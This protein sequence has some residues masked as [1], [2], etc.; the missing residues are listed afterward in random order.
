MEKKVVR[1]ELGEEKGGRIVRRDGDRE[2]C[3]D[4]CV[5]TQTTCRGLCVWA[6]QKKGLDSLCFKNISF[7]SFRGGMESTSKGSEEEEKKKKRETKPRWWPWGQLGKQCGVLWDQASVA[8]RQG[9]DGS[10][11]PCPFGGEG[12]DVHGER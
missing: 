8:K 3:V 9:G 11:A 1:K 6:S 7:S 2:V 4:V 12:G 5:T 10:T